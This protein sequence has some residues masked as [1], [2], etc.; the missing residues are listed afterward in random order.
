MQT[1]VT[2]S[3]KL[4][5]RNILPRGAANPHMPG[6]RRPHTRHSA[7][8]AL[9][10]RPHDGQRIDP[11]VLRNIVRRLRLDAIP[12]VEP[13]PEIDEPARQPA[14]GAV[15]VVLPCDGRTASRAANAARP[16]RAIIG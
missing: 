7:A 4:R 9:V 1:A 13:E 14:E 6:L 5:R 3:V 2:T 11:D 15:R 12:F 8:S 10:S 16:R